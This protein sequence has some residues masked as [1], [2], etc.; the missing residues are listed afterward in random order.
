MIQTRKEFQDHKFA[1]L[2]YFIGSLLF[3]AAAYDWL[4][5]KAG[6]PLFIALACGV[7][8]FPGPRGTDTPGSTTMRVL[9]GRALMRTRR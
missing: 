7:L 9:C 6:E 1:G 3:L 2:T 4:R 5:H 8:F